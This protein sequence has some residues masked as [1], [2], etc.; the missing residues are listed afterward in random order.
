MNFTEQIITFLTQVG[1][2]KDTRI[3]AIGTNV[4]RAAAAIV[5]WAV[6]VTMNYCCC[7]LL[8]IAATI[9]HEHTRYDYGYLPLPLSERVPVAERC[10]SFVIVWYSLSGGRPNQA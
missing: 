5:L 2:I 10:T 7:C 8:L 6:I 3:S 1:P 9:Q 4:N